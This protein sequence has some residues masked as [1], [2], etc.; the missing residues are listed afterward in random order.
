MTWQ[1]QIRTNLDD[2]AYRNLLQPLVEGVPGALHAALVNVRFRE[3]CGRSSDATED[4]AEI[5][6]L[7]ALTVGLFGGDPPPIQNAA[8]EGEVPD[9][10][11]AY[12]DAFLALGE[13]R[14]AY[15]VTRDETLLLARLDRNRAVVFATSSALNQGAAAAILQ[16][17]AVELDES[18]KAL[19]AHLDSNPEVLSG[20]IVDLASGAVLERHE[21]FRGSEVVVG[22]RLAAAMQA[23]FSGT[24]PPPGLVLETRA[25]DP[26]EVKRAQIVSRLQSVHWTRVQYDPEHLLVLTAEPNVHRGLVWSSLRDREVEVVRLW[27]DGLLSYGIPSTM[28]PFPQTQREFLEIVENLRG[29]DENDLLGRLD[30]G[31]FANYTVG[32]G[33]DMQ[34]CMECI[35]YLPNRR[36]CDL[37]ELPLPV[38]PDWWCRLWKI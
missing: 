19:D 24:H 4:P 18:D 6:Q 30:I 10:E 20:A 11:E 9:L 35:Y 26:I 36:W 27:V 28:S 5:Q 33:Q 8:P 31:G 15:L 13:V 16:G 38:E 3:V 14:S 17:I 34:R 12:V 29:L 2:E 1:P 21:R 25:G 7:L 22:D 37:P 23:L 32:D